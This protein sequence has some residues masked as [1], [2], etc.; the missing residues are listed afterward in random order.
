DAGHERRI[1]LVD[2][3]LLWAGRH[4]PLLRVERG[5]DAL[6]ERVEGERPGQEHEERK[7]VKKRIADL[8]QNPL[9]ALLQHRV[10]VHRVGS[11]GVLAFAG[12]SV[13]SKPEAP[14]STSKESGSPL[15]FRMLSRVTAIG[16][17]LVATASMK[18]AMFS[19]PDFFR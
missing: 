2:E 12:A 16:W 14:T 15:R 6:F 17:S 7:E 1:E 5:Y 18:R 13:R 11:V 9:D 3:E 4:A 8:R 10:D 19:M